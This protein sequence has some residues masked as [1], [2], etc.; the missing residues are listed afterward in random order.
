MENTLHLEVICLPS[1][2]VV[3]REIEGETVIVP[4]TTG[5]GDAEDELY[6]LNETGQAI[7]QKLDGKR[8]LKETAAL[9][10]DEFNEPLADCERDVLGFASEL[11]R[12]GILTVKAEG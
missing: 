1:A 7:W 3:A 11:A 6:T 5:I 9:L 8:T 4:L 12:R 10:A 2:N